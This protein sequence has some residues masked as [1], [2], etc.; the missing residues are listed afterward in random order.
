MKIPDAT[1][2]MELLLIAVKKDEFLNYFYTEI[3]FIQN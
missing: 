1:N 3:N 2:V